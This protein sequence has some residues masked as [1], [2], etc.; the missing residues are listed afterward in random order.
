MLYIVLINLLLNWP[1][2]S[3]ILYS[4]NNTNIQTYYIFY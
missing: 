3:S 2:E 1:V 4:F